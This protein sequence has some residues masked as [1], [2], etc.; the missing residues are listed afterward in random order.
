MERA[1]VGENQQTAN[2]EH[3]LL[4]P[5]NGPLFSHMERIV[6]IEHAVWETNQHSP[7]LGPSGLPAY[8]ILPHVLY[9]CICVRLTAKQ[10]I[11]I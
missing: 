10:G 7:Q 11:N 1:A 8:H 4:K 3:L 9:I 2:I 6:Q 5:F